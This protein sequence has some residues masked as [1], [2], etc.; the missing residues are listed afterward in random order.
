[1]AANGFTP[2]GAL[3]KA[4]LINSGMTLTGV[5]QQNSP[6]ALFCFRGWLRY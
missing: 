6:F 2:S 3:L 5:I 1:V 4:T